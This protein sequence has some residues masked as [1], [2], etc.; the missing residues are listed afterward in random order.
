MVSRMHCQMELVDTII[1]LKG[2]C[3]GIK[4]ALP[5]GPFEFMITSA[6]STV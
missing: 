2:G 4:D 5:N 6:Y 1:L 3:K